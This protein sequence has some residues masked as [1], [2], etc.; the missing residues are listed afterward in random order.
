MKNQ[1]E[2]IRLTAA[3]GAQV[4]GIALQ[5]IG[6]TEVELVRKLLNEHMVLFFPAQHL[7]Q[8]AHVALGRHFGRLEGHPN[9]NNPVAEYPEIFQLTASQGGI[10]DEWHSDLTF[11]AQ[12]S[13]MS[14]L[15]MLK[16]PSVGGDTMWANMV[17]AYE[18]L[19]APLRDLCD[20]LTALHD[21]APHGR[22]D[23]TAIH[24]VVRVHPVTGRKS[25]F[26][27]EHFTRRI[28]EL[29]HE[30]SNMLL[31]YLRRWVSNP[32]FTVRNRWTQGTIAMWDNRCTQH[33]VI[34]DFVGERMIQ[35]VTIVGDEPKGASA[36]RW[37]SFVRPE[38]AGASSRYDEQLNQH[39]GHQHLGLTKGVTKGQEKA[40]QAIQPDTNG[41]PSRVSLTPSSP[42][43]S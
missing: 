28:V 5:Q 14:I 27:N 7:D 9:L 12:P 8:Q 23:L 35:R 36:P 42:F 38:N 4:H 16:C 39:L 29:S 26:V 20:G 10:A 40:S 15:N 6:P 37:Q 30:E 3:L 22:T 13:I 25:L 31:G 24:P 2:V 34:N 21:A 41:L 43:Q 32:R 11:Q 19:S 17:H 33:F 18:G 1:P